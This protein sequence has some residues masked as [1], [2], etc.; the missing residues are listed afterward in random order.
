MMGAGYWGG[1]LLGA[2]VKDRAAISTPVGAQPATVARAHDLFS[3]RTAPT[4]TAT[5]RAALRKDRT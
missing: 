4:A 2:E 5:T 1:M 3:H